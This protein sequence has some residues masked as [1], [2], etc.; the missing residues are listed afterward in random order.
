MGVLF[1]TSA[2]G[3]GGGTNSVTTGSFDTA[4]T[5]R[6][7]IVTSDSSQDAG[8]SGISSSSGLTF[9]QIE[10]NKTKGAG[11]GVVAVWRA[12][13]SSQLA[14]ETVTVTYTS[15]PHAS[16]VVMVFSGIDI[17][18]TNGSGAIGAT[19][20]ANDTTFGSTTIA[21]SVTT[22]RPGSLVIGGLGESSNKTFTAN[23][24]ETAVILNGGTFSTG[25]GERENSSTAASGTNV[26]VGGTLSAGMVWAAI[27]VELLVAKVASQNN[28]T[29]MGVS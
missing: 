18:G 23:S 9:V 2:T 24:G 14:T 16:V 8:P 11:N 4:G 17:T 7:I 22:T 19:A 6:I 21:V 28:L 1:V 27:G 29:L 26:T 13:A 20:T 5:N 12:L 25:I 3:G 10:S 15:L